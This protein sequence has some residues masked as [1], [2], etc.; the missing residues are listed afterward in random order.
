MIK[1]M[2]YKFIL[3]AVSDLANNVEMLKERKDIFESYDIDLTLK[4][5]LD[6]V[7]K[8]LSVTPGNPPRVKSW[9]DLN[10]DRENYNKELDGAILSSCKIRTSYVYS[11]FKISYNGILL[12]F[13]IKKSKFVL[14]FRAYYGVVKFKNRRYVKALLERAKVLD[15]IIGAEDESGKRGVPVGVLATQIYG[16][17]LSRKDE[18]GYLYRKLNRILDSLVDSGELTKKDG[19]IYSTTGKAVKSLY[20]WRNQKLLERRQKKHEIAIIVLTFILAI[21]SVFQ[22]YLSGGFEEVWEGFLFFCK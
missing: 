18:F 6:G 21:S 1:E 11:G 3:A 15:F 14:F 2:Y 9:E 12:P 4:D 8:K 7:P 5:E 22:V 16:Y 17:N 19:L 13:L 20:E 10:H